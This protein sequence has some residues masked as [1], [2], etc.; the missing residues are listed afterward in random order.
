MARRPAGRPR[1]LEQSAIGDSATT[2]NRR[3]PG[4]DFVLIRLANTTGVTQ[5][6][7]LD[8]RVTRQDAILPAAG[9][10][11]PAEPSED[12]APSIS[13]V[14]TDCLRLTT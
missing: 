10:L 12:R 2:S 14:L 6:A 9:T 4:T 3:L 11:M 5:L 7:Q 13:V 1:I 8:R